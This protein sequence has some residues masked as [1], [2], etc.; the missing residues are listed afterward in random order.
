MGAASRET[1][2]AFL[3]AQIGILELEKEKLAKEDAALDTEIALNLS[4]LRMR[5]FSDYARVSLEIAGFLVVL[6]IVCGLG[7]MVW[8]ATQD[9]DLVV[10]AFSVPADVAQSG[11]T[12]DVLAGRVLDRLGHMQADTY[13]LTE[14]AGSYR[15]NDNNQV[16]IEIPS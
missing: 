9:H 3:E 15:S 16:R 5:R 4:H 10:D 14:G 8:N 6:L 12:G 1:G 7:T 11:M 13:S 2:D